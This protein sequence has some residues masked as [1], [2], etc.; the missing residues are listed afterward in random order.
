MKALLFLNGVPPKKYPDTA[1]YH[2]VFAVDGAYNYLEKSSIDPTAVLGDLDSL[3]NPKAEHKIHLPDQNYTDFEKSL[4]YLYA[5][6]YT[7]IDIYGASGGEQD[8]FLGNL[9]VALQYF[10]KLKLCFYDDKQTYFV[11]E[12]HTQLTGVRG[13]NISIIPFPSATITSSGLHYELKK[14]NLVFNTC[15]SI[16]NKAISD[17][18]TL[19]VLSGNAIIFLER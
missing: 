9:S 11:L 3:K 2:S 18:V 19:S 1:L 15:I 7:E 4:K 6:G 14:M 5:E 17:T 8:H 16:R 13:K 10:S 12:E